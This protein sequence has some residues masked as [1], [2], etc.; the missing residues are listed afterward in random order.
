MQVLVAEHG[1]HCFGIDSWTSG[2]ITGEAGA[3]FSILGVI[4]R[5]VCDYAGTNG[6]D[7]AAVSRSEGL[8]S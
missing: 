3:V 7:D 1:D 5:C 8:F 4:T 6:L 2:R